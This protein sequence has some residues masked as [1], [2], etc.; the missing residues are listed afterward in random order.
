MNKNLETEYKNAVMNDLPDLWD[1]IEAALPSVGED[2]NDKND[3]VKVFDNKNNTET[4]VNNVIPAKSVKKKKNLAWV[5]IVVPMAAL[6]IVLIAP[7]ILFFSRQNT[8]NVYFYNQSLSDSAP[9]T[10]AE[11]E[12]E[13]QEPGCEAPKEKSESLDLNG[14]AFFD[15]QVLSDEKAFFSCGLL[16][17]DFKSVVV[18]EFDD[19]GAFG[20]ADVV[21]K[22]LDSIVNSLLVFLTEKMNVEA[23]NKLLKV[24]EEPPAMTQFVLI[25]HHPEKVLQTIASRC[26]RIRIVPE[27]MTHTAVSQVEEGLLSDLM[28]ALVSKDLLEA[29]EVGEGIAAL[30]SRENIKAFCKFASERMRRVPDI[31]SVCMQ[32]ILRCS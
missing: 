21:M 18:V 31:M 5:K 10:M 25:S 26:Q 20:L 1:R 16:S 2:D 6:G 19:G 32:D 27:R 15:Y 12:T 17:D 28:S 7:A 8:K 24:I 3:S 4:P 29:I 23:A 11:V 9:S 30:P 13:V 14:N 22:E